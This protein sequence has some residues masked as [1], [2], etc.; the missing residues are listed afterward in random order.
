MTPWLQRLHWGQEQVWALPSW[1]L[2]HPSG[3][4]ILMGPMGKDEPLCCSLSGT[5]NITPAL[6]VLLK[7]CS[8]KVVHGCEVI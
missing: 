8:F 5:G 7:F 3:L 2:H 6:T 1:T 4:G